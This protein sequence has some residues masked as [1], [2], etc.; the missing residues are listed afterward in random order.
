V[1]H[2]RKR[3]IREAPAQ[4]TQ[5]PAASTANGVSRAPAGPSGRPV[6][7]TPKVRELERDARAVAESQLLNTARTLVMDVQ[8]AFVDVLQARE[9]LELARQNRQAFERIV[10]I[11]TARVQ[12]GDLAKV[13]LVRTRVAALQFQNAVRQAESRVKV[14]S[15]K[16]QTLMG[17][18]VYSPAFEAMGD[19]RRDLPLDTEEELERQAVEMRPDLT[20]LKRDE[21]RSA[22]EVT[23]T[24]RCSGRTRS[25][26]ASTTA[27]STTLRSSRTLP[28]QG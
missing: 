22:A 2:E 16:L 10:E 26:V 12:A 27:R 7:T 20:A 17:R 4:A 21:A 24:G 28:G 3:A 11:N 15:N 25:P 18:R 19:L 5:E 14:A 6:A 9:S 8:S 23:E 1:K 13:E